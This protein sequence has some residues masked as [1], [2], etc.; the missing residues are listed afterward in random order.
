MPWIETFR[1][2]FTGTALDTSKWNTYYW[3]GRTY[4]A[5]GELQYYADEALTVVN[6]TLRIT[7]RKTPMGGCAYTSGMITTLGKFSQQYGRFEIRCK[8]VKGKG[9]WPCF[10]L[11][12]ASK[13]WPPDMSVMEC[14]GHEP[15]TVHLAYHYTDPTGKPAT[16]S[17]YFT[18]PDF[19][20]EYHTF[21]MEWSPGKLQF[22]VDNYERYHTNASPQEQMYLLVNMAV[23]GNFPGNPDAT[24]IFPA[25]MRVDHI[26]V[27]QWED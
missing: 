19:T 25:E 12:P 7:A 14:L 6:G 17:T 9:L 21:C 26:R 16:S 22:Y 10:W 15:T 24:T 27:S 2:D 13:L 5:N 23:G 11:L 1:D 20:A 18:G 8:L 4:H 3:R